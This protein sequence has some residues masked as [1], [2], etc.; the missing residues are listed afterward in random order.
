[1]SLIYRMIARA[2][3]NVHYA[4]G[5]SGMMCV[6]HTRT[7]SAQKHVNVSEGFTLSLISAGDRTGRRRRSPRGQSGGR[8]RYHSIARTGRRRRFTT[9][10]SGGTAGLVASD[11]I[12]ASVRTPTSFVLR[13]AEREL[14]RCGLS[15]RLL[16]QKADEL[17]MK[18]RRES[19]S[20]K[21]PNISALENWGLTLKFV[22][23]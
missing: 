10:S 13:V 9:G 6:L 3:F 20:L 19:V 7:C 2:A 22:K 14:F 23:F 5:F 11:R 18:I 4:K 21:E 16:G 12:S 17:K 1:M 8:R 15:E